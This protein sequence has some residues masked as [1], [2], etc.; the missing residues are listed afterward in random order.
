MTLKRLIITVVYILSIVLCFLGTRWYYTEKYIKE[1]IKRSTTNV[2]FYHLLSSEVGNK[3]QLVKILNGFNDYQIMLLAKDLGVPC[4]RNI[5]MQ[6]TGIEQKI[7]PKE[8]GE[9]LIR[10]VRKHKII[11]E[12]Q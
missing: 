4:N 3:E 10:S 2:E 8:F 11:I 5:V 12:H 1:S 7:D 9:Q 6:K